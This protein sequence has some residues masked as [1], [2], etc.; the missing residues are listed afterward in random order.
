MKTP[1]TKTATGPFVKTNFDKAAVSPNYQTVLA[2]S[3]FKQTTAPYSE[4]IVSWDVSTGRIRWQIPLS[5]DAHLLTSL[6]ISPDGRIGGATVGKK[7]ILMD[8]ISGKILRTLELND[9]NVRW[10][11]FSPDSR[12]VLLPGEGNTIELRTVATG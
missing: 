4:S 10:I 9:K 12:K 5:K 6:T 11:S 3:G 7:L 1:K 8:M 2:K